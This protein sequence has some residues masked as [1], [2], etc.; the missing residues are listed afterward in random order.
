MKL[1][2][3][4]NGIGIEIND[5]KNGF[6]FLS[7]KIGKGELVIFTWDIF[8]KA[9]KSPTPLFLLEKIMSSTEHLEMINHET[10]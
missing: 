10:H 6:T 7:A 8:G 5:N 9:D 3:F 2:P 4:D 1:I